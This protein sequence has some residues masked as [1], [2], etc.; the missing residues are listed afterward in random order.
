M[1]HQSSKPVIIKRGRLISW[2]NAELRALF[3]M[4]L[5]PYCRTAEVKW[6]AFF[7][8]GYK[9]PPGRNPDFPTSVLAEIA[10]VGFDFI[11]SF[12]LPALTYAL[13]N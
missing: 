13:I 4:L 7:S 11:L 9:V 8:P 1:V 2:Q 10:Q 6:R 5:L 3:F 12:S